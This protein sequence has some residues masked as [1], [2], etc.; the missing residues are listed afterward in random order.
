MLNLALTLALLPSAAGNGAAV[1][2]LPYSDAAARYLESHGLATNPEAQ[3]SLE[4]ILAQSNVY[5][6][7]GMFRVHFPRTYLQDRR[8]ASEFEKAAVALLDLQALWMEWSA[9]A[10]RARFSE[11][12]CMTDVRKWVGSWTNSS[13]SRVHDH[14]ESASLELLMLAPQSV[15]DASQ[16]LIRGMCDGSLLGLPAAAPLDPITLALAPTREEFIGLACAL[17]QL[18]PEHQAIFWVD[19]LPGWTHMRLNDFFALSLEYASV[20]QKNDDPLTGYDMNSREKTGVTQHIL[21]HA[22][23]RMCR[24]VYGEEMDPAF[25]DA[26]C[27]KSV[28]DILG[29][30]NARAGGSGEAR[31]TDA[32][33]RFI[34]GF[35]NGGTLP[36]NNADSRWRL[37]KG[38][39]Y[40]VGTLKNGQRDGKKIA[41]KDR[42]LR[43]T[44]GTIHFVLD[45]SDGRKAAAL[46]QAPFLGSKV[47]AKNIGRECASDYREFFRSYKAAFVYW[48]QHK[49]GKA[50]K[51]RKPEEAFAQVLRDTALAHRDPKN[52][53]TFEERLESVYGSPYSEPSMKE[54]SLEKEFLR[55]LP[56]G[57][58]FPTAEP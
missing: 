10:T 36:P 47:P 23:D 45:A 8:W 58:R 41:G 16:D 1:D 5:V 48:L 52:T 56:K 49:S 13:L 30:N 53:T 38:T 24:R 46:I 39:D 31:K 43:K 9:E 11:P 4:A 20:D 7:L 2:R 40:F 18:S 22:A 3:A 17:G 44:P 57:R 32:Q 6:D 29:E 42:N 54:D 27:L 25:R 55:W 14:R 15:R 12:D 37:K 26:L 35:T 19:Q 33:S 51:I 21:N 28:V 34:P 50:L